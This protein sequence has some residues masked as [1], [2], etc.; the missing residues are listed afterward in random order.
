MRVQ[1]RLFASLREAAR[2]DACWVTLH[3]NAQGEDIKRV[4]ADRLPRLSGLLESTRLARNLDYVSWDIPV[5][6]GDEL[7]LIPPVSGG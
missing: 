1:V 3:A 7:S 6:D 4:L 2:T 5:H